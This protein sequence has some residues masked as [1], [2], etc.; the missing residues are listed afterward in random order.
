[1]HPYHTVFVFANFHVANSGLRLEKSLPR[2]PKKIA[3][4][5]IRVK[6]G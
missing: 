1:L 2:L 5:F 4:D 3:D 6:G